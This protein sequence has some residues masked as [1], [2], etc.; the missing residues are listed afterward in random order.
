MPV[1]VSHQTLESV[2]QTIVSFAR[3][4]LGLQL[5]GALEQSPVL[6]IDVRV[7]NALVLVPWEPVHTFAIGR[8]TDLQ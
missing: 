1:R 8:T 5:I 6:A 4:H 2:D 7:A 3:R